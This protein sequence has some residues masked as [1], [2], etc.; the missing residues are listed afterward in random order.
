MIKC[1]S[2]S[3]GWVMGANIQRN[4]HQVTPGRAV[5]GKARSERKAAPLPG[6][7]DDTVPFFFGRC[8]REHAC[9][10]EDRGKGSIP[11]WSSEQSS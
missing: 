6:W 2:F 11:H 3:F 1:A 5:I 7:G 10:R 8:L 9:V 4:R